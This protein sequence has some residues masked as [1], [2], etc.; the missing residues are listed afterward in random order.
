MNRSADAILM[1]I[2]TRTNFTGDIGGPGNPLIH[3]IDSSNPLSRAVIRG[4][5]AVYLSGK[6]GGTFNVVLD[7]TGSLNADGNLNDLCVKRGTATIASTCDFAGF[8]ILDG[9]AAT[10]TMAD[11]DTTEQH[12]PYVTIWNGTLND[13]RQV[14][15]VT[16]CIVTV[17][18]GTFNLT[19]PERDPLKV[20]VG[21]AGTYNY[22]NTT[23]GS[24]AYQD[25]VC[26]GEVD[27][28]TVASPNTVGHVFR[29][30]L[31]NTLG[32]VNQSG[33]MDVSSADVDLREE[34]P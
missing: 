13:N 17:F 34:Y 25:I 7:T 3:A 30:Q 1:R 20:F 24:Y 26:A 32:A 27:F 21:P 33:V 23:G 28:S 22:T 9:P 11:I 19:A 18:G 10:V 15:N 6:V 12:P 29:G 5:G 31:A 4:S 16:L 8:L 14:E 2:I